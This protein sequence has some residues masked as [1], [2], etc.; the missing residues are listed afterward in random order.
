MVL[1]YFIHSQSL[2][3]KLTNEAGR[4]CGV[5]L[6]SVREHGAPED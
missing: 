6:R 2:E 1:V 3:S 4:G 5:K